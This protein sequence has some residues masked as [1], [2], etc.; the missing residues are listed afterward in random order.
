MSQISFLYITTKDSSEAEKIGRHF[1]ESK[2]AA[3]VNIFPKMK[4]IY[5]WKGKIA[6]A[7]EAVLIVKTKTELVPK[8]TEEVKKLHSYECPCIVSIPIEGGNEEFLRWIQ[9]SITNDE[10]RLNEKGKM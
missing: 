4:S 9:E 5:R 3:C 2:L 10:L 8:I 7:D 1:V 6:S